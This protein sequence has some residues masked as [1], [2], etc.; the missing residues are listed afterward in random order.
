M[1]AF[2]SATATNTNFGPCGNC[3]CPTGECRRNRNTIVI[4]YYANKCG[5]AESR[6]YT[7]WVEEATAALKAAALAA[8]KRAK[9]QAGWVW[10]QSEKPRMFPQ[11]RV[12]DYQRRPG[13]PNRRLGRARTRKNCVEPE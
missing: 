8:T 3:S 2:G 5:V 7:R 13:R 1:A 12:R 6:E 9:T 11:C 10:D 4:T